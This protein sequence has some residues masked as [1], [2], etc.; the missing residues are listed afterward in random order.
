MTGA[1]GREGEERELPLVAV[2]SSVPMLSEALSHAL[3]GIAEVHG[4]PA[5]RGDTS[6]LLRWLQPDGVVVD[7]EEEAEAAAEY[8]QE[9][10]SPLVLVSYPDEKLRIL[11]DGSWQEPEHASPS[12]EGIRNILVGGLFGRVGRV[13]PAP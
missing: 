13:A 8:A 10:E 2:V 6:G 7:S 4:F 11:R 9:T 5:E 12:L 1:G 3:E